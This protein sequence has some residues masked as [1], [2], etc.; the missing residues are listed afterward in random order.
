MEA[1]DLNGLDILD[2][3]LSDIADLPGYDVPVNGRYQ[4]EMTAAVKSVNDKPA[5][6]ISLTV[7]AL[8]SQQNDSDAPTPMDT[9][10]SLLFFLAGEPDAVKM[11]LGRL[12]ELADPALSEHYSTGNLKEIISKLAEPLLIEATVKRRQDKTDKDKYYG[13]IKDL[14]VC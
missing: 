11:S 7:K 12:K 1:L 9:K 3:D 8:I 2:Q 5:V 10:F 13:S 6:E 14:S 4:M